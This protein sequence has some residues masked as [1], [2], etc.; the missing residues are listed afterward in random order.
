[1][2]DLPSPISASTG[3]PPV[4]LDLCGGTGSWSRPYLEAGYDVRLVTLPET[5]VRLYHP[6][7][8]VHGVLAAPPCN[9]FA[10]SGARWPRTEEE[11]LEGLSVVDACLRIAMTVEPEWWVL[12]NPVGR[13]VRW[14]GK[15]KMYF[16]PCD[17]GDP[18]TKKTALWGQ[19]NVPQ[20]SPVE[21]VEGS[22]MYKSHAGN[23][24]SKSKEM[25]AVTPPRFAKAFFIANP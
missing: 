11:M 10:S 9:V 7:L 24:G 17:Y 12:E 5:D 3:P 15:P 6:P 1:M 8:K 20:C 18:Y 2:K 22:R 4:I 19:F 13:L 16:Q 25:R 23:M 14:L 21:P